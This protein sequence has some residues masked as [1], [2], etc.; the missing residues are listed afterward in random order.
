MN[1][2]DAC[3]LE[4]IPESFLGEYDRSL[5]RIPADGCGLFNDAAN[6]LVRD[7]ISFYRVVALM[8]QKAPADDLNAVACLW[9]LMVRACDQTIHRLKT[10]HAQHPYC[11]ADTYYDRVLDL[12]NK[13]NRLETMHS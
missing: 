9:N 11:G 4:A 13:C 10:L 2:L 7:L 12:R 1:C 6:G 3:D 5:Q 8:T